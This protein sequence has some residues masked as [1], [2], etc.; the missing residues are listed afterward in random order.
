MYYSLPFPQYTALR[1]KPVTIEP[2]TMEFNID[3]DDGD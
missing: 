2:N 1:C 3:T